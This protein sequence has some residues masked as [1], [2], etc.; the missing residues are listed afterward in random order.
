[1]TGQ[2]DHSARTYANS[3]PVQT[4]AAAAIAE[5]RL[6]ATMTE[7][8]GR[9]TRRYLTPPVAEVHK[10]LRTRM[11]SLGMTVTRWTRPAIFAASGNPTRNDR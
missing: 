10:H 4:R 2:F 8:P 1:M 11:E 9:I 6:L 7:E 5:C 3:A